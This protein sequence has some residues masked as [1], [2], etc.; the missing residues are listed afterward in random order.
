[1]LESAV[2]NTP[3]ATA[4]GGPTPSG[5]AGWPVASGPRFA[6]VPIRVQTGG[7]ARSG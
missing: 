3:S 5:V 2:T 4:T 6:P 7:T 1:M